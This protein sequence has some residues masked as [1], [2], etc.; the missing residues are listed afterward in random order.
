MRKKTPYGDYGFESAFSN[1]LKLDIKNCSKE[2]I[3][4]IKIQL[5]RDKKLNQLL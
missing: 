3:E 2:D 1:I 4:K 5:K